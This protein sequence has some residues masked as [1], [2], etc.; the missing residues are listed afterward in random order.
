VV[1]LSDIKNARKTISDALMA[2]PMFSASRIGEASGGIE[3]FLK[4]ESLQKTGSFKPRGALNLIRNTPPEELGRGVITIS[5]GNHA[6]GVAWA[7]GAAGISATIVM[8]STA[9]PTKIAAS[10]GYGAEVVLIDGTIS[11]AF[12]ELHRIKEERNLTLIHPFDDPLLIAGHGTVGLEIVEQVPDVNVIV[13]P[14][15]GGGLISGVA[16]AAKAMKPDVR[17]YGIEPEGAPAMRKS[18]DAGSAQQL[19]SV[20]TIADGLAPPMVGKLN[21]ELTR[22]YVDDVIL[23][24]DTEIAIGIREIMT[25]VKLYAEPA[26]AAATAALLAGKVPVESGETVVALL[27]GG[28]MDIPKL[29]DILGKLD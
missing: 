18:W 27:S 29:L 8:Q 23:V 12:E 17:I 13:C 9:S 11:E 14:I 21:Y 26:G 19:E 6:Q 4:A 24:D 3:L 16:T 22:K 7:A 25:N 10:R 20:N 2:T 28:N 5:A 1:T 15:G